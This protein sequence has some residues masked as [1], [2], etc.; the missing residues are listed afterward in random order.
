[1]DEYQ[2]LLR[3]SVATAGND[4]R[5]GALEAPPAIVSMF[6]GDE[7]EG[8]LEAIETDTPYG[9]KEKENLK[10][11]VHVL[12]KFP[13]DTTDRNRTAPFAF[14]G[15]K[16]EFRMLGSSDSVAEPNVVLNTAAAEAL[17]QFADE[18]EGAEDFET[19]LH[20]LIQKTIR[21]HKRIIW[22]GNCYDE[23]WEKEAEKRGLLNL[24]TTPDALAR[25][26]DEK[27]VT[28]FANHKIYT[29]TE[30]RSRMEILLENYCKIV[31]IEART[32]VDMARKELL[33]AV[34]E[35]IVSLSDAV[36]AGNLLEED[37]RNSFEFATA[38]ELTS[39]KAAAFGSLKELEKSA[40]EAASLT[41]AAERALYLKDKVLPLMAELRTT[42]DT[43]ETL[44]AEDYWP[45]PT[46]GDLLFGVI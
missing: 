45:M 41:H 28:L 2:D 19:A 43:M 35:Y 1:M 32:M 13:K 39:L 33:P 38:K 23:S 26:L 14:T 25:L 27:N 40:N 22:G 6:L 44:T 21:K 24:K 36:A 3:I 15:N 9:A 46:Y 20:D 5:L 10:V 12:P 16:F 18:L 17:R 37:M 34:S 7:L 8:I 11:G 31:N 4:H 29:E 30:L 42:V